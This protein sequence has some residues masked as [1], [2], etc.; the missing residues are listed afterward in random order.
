VDSSNEPTLVPAR[1]NFPTNAGHS[2]RQR[3][4]VGPHLALNSPRSPLLRISI[5]INRSHLSTPENT[6]TRIPCL[7]SRPGIPIAARA[8]AQV[9]LATTSTPVVVGAATDMAPAAQTAIGGLRST[10]V[11]G[12][13]TSLLL[14]SVVGSDPRLTN[15]PRRMRWRLQTARLP[16]RCRGRPRPT[17]GVVVVLLRRRFRR[18][19]PDLLR[20]PRRRRRPRHPPEPVQLREIKPV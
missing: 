15:L 1:I 17:Q 11:R 7:V 18:R 9:A 2:P 19:N 3:C 14:A 20:I 13:S 4:V 5:T 8:I 16:F 12:R 6:T 10:T